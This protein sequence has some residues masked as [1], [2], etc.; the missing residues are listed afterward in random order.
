MENKKIKKMS[1]L[2]KSIL[3]CMLIAG[4]TAL[5][6]TG[7]SVSASGIVTAGEMVD[8]SNDFADYKVQQT[9]RIENDGIV[10]ALQYT[11]YYDYERLGNVVPDIYGT[12]IIVYAINTNTVRTGTDSNKTIIQSML[13]HGYVVVVLDYLGNS[14]ATSPKI[15]DSVQ[16]FTKNLKDGRYFDK[17]TD[18]DTSKAFPKSGAYKEIFVCPSGHNVLL[19]QVFWE[20]DKH[21]ANGTLEKIVENWNTDLKKAKANT[22]VKWANGTTT[23]TRKKVDVAADGTSP[24]WYNASG[25]T[26]VNGLYT[27]VK[28]T[29]AT[30][31]TDCVNPDGTALEM[32]LYLHLV[33]PTNPVNEVPVIT[34]S[35]AMGYPHTLARTAEYRAHHNGALFN[36]YAGAVYD[37]LYQPMARD[38]SF[39]YYDGSSGSTG[40]HMNY[41]LHIY[42]D[43]L[44]NT[45]AMRYLRYV[46]LSGGD[47]YN[48][49]LDKF[50]TI[51][52]SKGGWFSFLGE[53]V[54]QSELVNASD[55]ST[56]AELENAIND[57]LAGFTP[58]RIFDGHNGETRYQAGN[59]TT[60][61][62]GAYTGAYAVAG[63]EVQPWLTYE[64][65]EILSG[66][67]F[68]YAANGSQEEDISKGHSPMYIAAN[69]YDDYNAAYGSS[70][71]LVNLARS[72]DIPSVY[73]IV[74]LA[75]VYATGP[76]VDYGVDT[77]VAFFDFLN[78][79]MKDAPAKVLY[80]Y[81]MNT[82]GGV[83]VNE[84]IVIKFAGEVDASE[85]AKVTVSV[86]GIALRGTWES[87]Y[88]D[89][90]WTFTTGE[91]K[92]ATEYKITVPADLSGKNGTALGTAYESTF[93]TENGVT[94]DTAASGNYY[95]VTAP[96]MPSGNDTFTFRFFVSND[97]ANVAELYAVSAVG[98]TEGELI[99]SVNLSGMGGYEIDVTSYLMERAGDS[100]VLWL[101]TQKASAN[102]VIV[103]QSFNGTTGGVST[104]SKAPVSSVMLDANNNETTDSSKAVKTALRVHINDNN[105][106]YNGSVYYQ[107]VTTAFTFGN[108]IGTK[109]LTLDDYGRAFT[110]KLKVYDTVSRT[111]Q[112]KLN[113]MT[114]KAN[115]TIDLYQPLYNITTKAGE[116]MEI[117]IPYVVYDTDYG[118]VS[119]QKKS[120]TVQISPTG[121]SK[122]PMYF[123]DVS[124]TEH[125]TD[126]TVTTAS[127][128]ATNNGKAPHKAPTSDNAFTVYNGSSAV[129]SYNTWAAALGA[130]KSG[131]TVALN[132]DYTLVNA[133]LYS[134]ISALS[135]VTVDLNGYTLTAANTTNSLLWFK[136]TSL[137]AKESTVTL[138]NGGVVL[139]ATPLA[140]YENSTSQGSG[141]KI[142]INLEDVSFTLSRGAMTTGIVSTTTVADGVETLVNVTLDEC[143]FTVSERDRADIDI[144]MLPTGAGDLTVNYSV[145]GGSFVFD[146]QRRAYVQ[147]SATSSEFYKGD[148]GYATLTIASA[149]APDDAVS[150]LIS[151]GFASYTAK[152]SENGITTYELSASAN[153]TRYGIIPDEYLDAEKYPFVLFRDGVF[154]G[155]YETWAKASNGAGTSVN[156]DAYAK[157]SA[158]ILLRRD[159]NIIKGDN[160]VTL[161]K[162]TNIRLDLGGHTLTQA[163]IGFDLSGSYSTAPYTTTITILN[164]TVLNVRGL[165][166]IDSQYASGQT[167][168]K[169][170]SIVCENVAFGFAE[171]ADTSYANHMLWT[172]WNNNRDCIGT[173]N[174]ITFVDCTFNLRDNLP[175]DISASDPLYILGA[176]D[177]YSRSH[178]AATFKGGNIITADSQAI[179]IMNANVGDDYFVFDK[180]DKGEYTTLTVT[181]EYAVLGGD[182]A[183]ADGTAV[184]FANGVKNGNDTVYTLE[185]NTL[186][187]DY[188][189]IPMEYADENVYPFVVFDTKG[190]FRYAATSFYGT[191]ATDSAVGRAIYDVLKANVWDT[192]NKTYGASEI[193]AVIV[194]RRDYALTSS[195]K[196]DNLSYVQGTL[197]IDMGGYTLTQGSNYTFMPTTKA[198]ADS[199]DASIF[200]SNFRII[201]G[202]LAC[203]NYA[204]L[205]FD[206]RNVPTATDYSDKSMTWRFDGVTFKLLSGGTASGVL[207]GC[208]PNSGLKTIQ[209]TIVMNDCTIDMS[210][211]SSGNIRI[212]SNL[213]NSQLKIDINVYGGKIVASELES[214]TNNI[215]RLDTG[216]TSSGSVTFYPDANGE[217]TK[218][219][220]A[221]TAVNA[222]KTVCTLDTGDKLSFVKTKSVGTQNVY[223]LINLKTPYGTIDSKYASAEDYP[224]AVFKDGVFLGAYA[225]W[226]DCND[227]DVNSA[228][229]MAKNQMAGI[230]GAGKTVTVLLRRDFVNVYSGTNGK[231]NNYAQ[232]G[233]T[234]VLDLG[235]HSMT[236][237][238]VVLFDLSGKRV[239]TN[240]VYY[241]HDTKTVV[242]NG[243]LYTG[244]KALIS[245]STLGTWTEEEYGVKSFYFTF[246]NV[247]FA[248]SPTYSAEVSSIFVNSTSTTNPINFIPTF[249]NCTFDYSSHKSTASVTLFDFT[250]SGNVRLN[251]IVI[252]GEFKASTF[253]GITF[254]KLS[255]GD[256]ILFAKGNSG[257]YI[258]ALMADSG[259][260]TAE[261]FTT[262]DGKTLNF[263]LMSTADGIKTYELVDL[264]TPYGK[265]DPEYANPELYPFVIFDNNGFVKGAPVFYGAQS[266]SSAMHAAIYSVTTKNNWDPVNKTYGNNAKYAVILLRSDYTISSSEYFNNLAH[267][268]GTITIDLGGHTLTAASGQYMFTS[269]AKQWPVADSGDTTNVF[270][271]TFIIKNG[272]LK[273]IDKSLIA[274]DTANST[275]VNLL[276]KTFT[277]QFDNVTFKNEKAA[278]PLYACWHKTGLAK[279]PTY[280]I[281][282]D[283]TFDF[284]NTTTATNFMN[285][286]TGNDIQLHVTV[287]GGNL[288][289][290]PAKL[291]FINA[292]ATNGSTITFG[293]LDGG[294]YMTITTK[295]GQSSPTAK[296][297]GGKLEFVKISETA[298]EV[299]YR[300]RP[301]EVSSITFTPKTS[302]T[303]G[304]ELTYNVYVPVVD[305]L[306]SFTVDGKTYEDLIP[307]T[308]DDGNQ[309]YLVSVPMPASEAARNVVLKAIMTID[310]KEY[311][312]TF[313]MSIPKYVK[314]ILDSDENETE[315]TLV[316]DVLAYIKA[317]YIYFDAEDKTEVVKA[318]DEILGDYNNTFAKVDG[319]TD[320]DNGLWGVVIVLEDKPAIRFVLPEGVS[321]DGYMFKAGNIV[322]DFTT[323]T[324]TVGAKTYNYAEVSLYAYQM[325]REITY[326]N[327]TESGCYHINSYYDFVT[328]DNELKNDTNLISLVEKLYNYCKSAEVY[329]ASVTNK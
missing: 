273:S 142:S 124:V 64:G 290:D 210:A 328:T 166:F 298:D 125:I 301:V 165:A 205:L 164:G 258:K 116:W 5:V 209:T 27:K 283:C 229:E 284:S 245:M 76:D 194:M 327:G 270:P 147:T 233:G 36:G 144:V 256:K 239:L 33:Y 259:K 262:S 87:S 186:I 320:A 172:V 50:A 69:L 307:L 202:T 223:E 221:N 110:V 302:I 85:I 288:V 104:V 34:V 314:K 281:Y 129:G 62:S 155:A 119:N 39:G 92:P 215:V 249:D 308:L 311:N 192:A 57:V 325:I 10:G 139:G 61:E 2:K 97:A 28:W 178:L 319:T 278:T 296:A 170:Y 47:T 315:K 29:V 177:G 291:T 242:K 187:T 75:H 13:D 197:T 232:I 93:I 271:S 81:P 181:G 169:K 226:G 86:N 156:S 66:V 317:A 132:S 91:M 235:G 38:A 67:Q 316:K 68:T 237:D 286:S 71:V 51:G 206:I 60:Y 250:K 255:A 265:I 207:M 4:I 103:S 107:N 190:N 94:Y 127:I 203:K 244:N 295:P 19:N 83:S 149:Y 78:Y 236:S 99:G 163:G 117:E 152:S 128:N 54:L 175:T 63:G 136:N 267:N 115:N 6:I 7:M 253:A 137:N 77:Y 199:G 122:M 188:G 23:D 106:S 70:N 168:A 18:T 108:L 309:Y 79:Y 72:L 318:I 211:R 80:T 35:S 179:K 131:Y 272:T 58:Y 323:G 40:D 289:I 74:P 180:N 126:M 130:S 105:G 153:S 102:S 310:G 238:G 212:F 200:P 16:L 31:F 22:L 326:T 247:T 217:Y 160:G 42:N 260:I 14:A 254:A 44:V 56:I 322:L 20:I 204:A 198:W 52:L 101:K 26:D 329:R 161:N 133:D 112:I 120:F 109:N 300:L 264:N 113:G 299:V 65:K 174:A 43:K 312:G 3:L 214:G 193:G 138:K 150:Y 146:S 135:S 176:K 182:F 274:F 243:T 12:P 45:A 228:L 21:S 59:T 263:G 321:T 140:S 294:N 25:A 8:I 96:E 268:Q 121:E 134:G 208:Y 123:T 225:L 306:K 266:G 55:Y 95:T 159:F 37:Y 297:N 252:G 157:I 11:V 222:P 201:N 219:Y 41:S 231:Y 276:D 196:F 261:N 185:E 148:N 230:T 82:S 216:S 227:A 73:F 275:S 17:D 280:L 32:D 184:Y 220:L 240:G 143:K 46:S 313:T 183:T 287:N 151:N 30:T 173:E 9:A 84:D 285:L 89:T 100:V 246:E 189:A 324:M 167:N 292:S 195:E 158:D 303:L 257:S 251:A 234:L 293:K 48:F 141:K 305:Y 191:N 114:K 218:I 24:V 15:D 248:Q 241:I 269:T 88:G 1:L 98:S 49:A 154:I 171:G 53:E 224:F 277:W 213:T 111:L 145:I 118:V 90:Q 304:S 282:N 162:A 279:I